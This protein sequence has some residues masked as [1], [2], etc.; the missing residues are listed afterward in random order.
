[1]AELGVTW[2]GASAEQTI[3][4]R[5][6]LLRLDLRQLNLVPN[7]EALNP[8]PKDGT[9]TVPGQLLLQL[10]KSE[11]ISS[12]ASALQIED[13]DE[14]QEDAEVQYGQGRMKYTCG[15][16][17]LRVTLVEAHCCPAPSGA[18]LVPGSKLLLKG[19]S[20]NQL[21][22]IGGFV[23][24]HSPSQ[25]QW[26]GGEV[27]SQAAAFEIAKRV[28]KSR[29]DGANELD[30]NTK[31]IPFGKSKRP[32]AQRLGGSYITAGSILQSDFVA[33]A[34]PTVTATTAEPVERQAPL[35]KTDVTTNKIIT[36]SNHPDPQAA[37]RSSAPARGR[38]GGQRGGRG[39][40]RRGGRD[41][42]IIVTSQAGRTLYGAAPTAS[43]APW[44]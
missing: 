43:G 8:P 9:V 11:C 37:S 42:G 1:M 18:E 23:M 27:E 36:T 19:G 30:V 17:K 40:N 7:Y 41:Q 28:S 44:G 10:M 15:L 5:D 14:P 38:R 12:R 25:I 13:P 24:L 21:Q 4:A 2:D 22:F 16:G 6:E 33:A 26:I 35:K 31:F 39:S 29:R 32:I 34:R 20:N 3:P